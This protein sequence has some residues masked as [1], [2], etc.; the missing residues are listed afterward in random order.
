MKKHYKKTLLLLSS[1]Y[2][3]SLFASMDREPVEQNPF[4]HKDL[5]TV[6]Q[7]KPVEKHVFGKHKN[8][9]TFNRKTEYP[10]QVFV[11]DLIK[12]IWWYASFRPFQEREDLYIS[13][14]RD[15]Q[16]TQVRLFEKEEDS[17]IVKVAQLRGEITNK[18][19]LKDLSFQAI[20]CVRP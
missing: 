10:L 1:L 16:K 14:R 11:E 17:F 13:Y 2:T 20:R 6:V 12:D 7:C 4:T 8:L 19:Q 5:E 9:Q 18:E 15:L 3:S